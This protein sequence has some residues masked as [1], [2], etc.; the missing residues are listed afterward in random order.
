MKLVHTPEQLGFISSLRDLFAD[1][2]PP[3]LVRQMK[4]PD[5]DG[6]PPKLWESLANV[7]AFGL[8]IDPEFG[9]SGA[10]LYELGLLFGEAGRVLCPTVVYSTLI[11]GVA[12]QRLA[13]EDQAKRLLPAL[14]RGELKAT[15]AMWNP[16]DAGDTRPA[17]T[18]ERTEAGWKLRGEQLFVPNARLADMV[19][20][21]ARTAASGEPG[22]VLG[23]FAEPGAPGWSAEPLRT[24]AGD[25]QARLVLEDHFVADA[26]AITGPDGAGI[27]AA[28]LGWISSAAVS[29]QC[30][31]M[32]GGATAVLERTVDY[33]KVREQFGRPLASF[34]AAQHLI[35]DMRMA[36]DGA[37][38]TANQA[39]WWLGRGQPAPR[40]VAIAKMQCSEAYKWA[41]LNGHQLHGGMGFVRETDLHLWSERAKATEIQGG[42]ADVAAGW[43]QRELDLTS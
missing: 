21:T 35:A 23:F 33:L 10:G 17:F 22:R 15:T 39:V 25:K 26:Q 16:A 40:A 19:L 38:L 30:M 31:E 27:T 7:G 20:V 4:E 18:A 29:L 9:G 14:A 13:D 11:F 2:C 6:F 3:A 12:A 1:A 8:T 37:R 32:V 41:T 24:M 28:D 34:Q 42:T 43:L 5:S 36:I